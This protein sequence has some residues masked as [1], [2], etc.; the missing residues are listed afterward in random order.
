[1]VPQ[2]IGSVRFIDGITRTVLD[3]DG[4]QCVLDG[5]EA[6]YGVWILTD[7]ML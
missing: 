1:M 2:P 3:A 5:D 6:V 7:D 4:R